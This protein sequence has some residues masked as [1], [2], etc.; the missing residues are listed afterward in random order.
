MQSISFVKP[1]PRTWLLIK[2]FIMV[3]THPVYTMKYADVNNIK[4]ETN[5][6][7]IKDLVGK[8]ILTDNLLVAPIVSQTPSE[9]N[10][11][12]YKAGRTLPYLIYP[13]YQTKGEPRIFPFWRKRC[14]QHRWN[15]D[16]WERFLMQHAIVRKHHKLFPVEYIIAR[17]F[18]E[19][20]SFKL[21]CEKTY[22]LKHLTPFYSK[23]HCEHI[24]VV[25]LN[26]TKFKDFI[27][28]EIK[29]IF[30]KARVNPSFL[31]ESMAANISALELKIQ[32][33]TGESGYN[34]EMVELCKLQHAISKDVLEL[35]LG[36]S[37]NGISGIGNT[38][39]LSL[40]EPIKGIV[41]KNPTM[42]ITNE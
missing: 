26:T 24:M 42:E 33:L 2:D 23:K 4:Y 18:V 30:Q 29:D 35:Y 34:S 19:T 41:N 10:L 13:L 40:P 5:W 28:R 31:I 38:Q 6:R 17:Y 20:L 12:G 37:L 14:Y 21:A 15:V 7:E 22:G 16:V 1:I 11:P 3:G 27:M 32:L 9:I 8:Y 39:V 36:E 25:L